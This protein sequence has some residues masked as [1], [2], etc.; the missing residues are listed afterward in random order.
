MAALKPLDRQGIMADVA[1]NPA[2]MMRRAE[3]AG[4]VPA[5]GKRW[6]ATHKAGLQD[7][8]GY[9]GVPLS[10]GLELRIDI[11]G[12]AGFSGGPAAPPPRSLSVCPSVPTKVNL[13]LGP[14]IRQK[15]RPPLA[16]A[17][18][19]PFFPRAVRAGFAGT[20]Y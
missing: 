20:C 19:L 1:K 10:R 14:C 9:W 18:S 16:L 5:D 3:A 8:W 11:H 7:D 2:G 13:Q 15:D 6:S 4:V 17:P 12:L